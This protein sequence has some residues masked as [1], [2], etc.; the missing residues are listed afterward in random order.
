MYI[1]TRAHTYAC[2]RTCTHIHIHTPLTNESISRE[3]GDEES[4]NEIGEGRDREGGRERE[5]GRGM[6]GGKKTSQYSTLNNSWHTTKRLYQLM[7][8]SI[9]ISKNRKIRKGGQRKRKLTIAG[10]Q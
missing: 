8:L 9:A 2:T 6:E 3:R 5:G 10:E 7:V 4:G 1:C